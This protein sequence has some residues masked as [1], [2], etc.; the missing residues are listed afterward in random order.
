MVELTTNTP[1][2]RHI[3]IAAMFS[4]ILPGLGQLY[5]GRLKRGLLLNFL[6]ILPLPLIIWLFR[7]S[8]AP[9]VMQITLLLIVAGGIV[10]LIAICD[11]AVLAKRAGSTYQLKDYNSPLVYI[12]FILIVTGGSIGS[13]LHLRDQTIEA[14]IVPAAS[15]YPTIVPNDRILANKSAYKTNEP[16]R[17]DLIVF[18]NP[19]NRHINFIKRIIAIPGDTVQIR[20]GQVYV[21]DLKLPRQAL[22]ASTLD[23]I[24]IDTPHQ[25]AQAEVFYETNDQAK[26][27][28]ILPTPTSEQSTTAIDYPKTTVPQHHCFVLGD[29]RNFSY[30][31]RNFG[32]IPLATIK[33]RAD[34]LYWPAKDWSRLGK[35]DR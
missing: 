32:P 24:A 15:C 23:D 35:L 25:P 9:I 7:L 10:Q 29:N 1:G 26:Y 18:S 4:L 21:N 12:L 22:P 3:W 6:N 16:S 27:K 30:D 17:G 13:A 2:K 20:D 33:G 31:S 8:T 14:F 19:E 5:C 28:I 34:Y 11:S